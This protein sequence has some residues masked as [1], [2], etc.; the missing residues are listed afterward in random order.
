MAERSTE[1]HLA[2]VLIQ[3]EMK[4]I[5][6]TLIL[7]LFVNL[8][9]AQNQSNN[10][11]F[12][13]N[14]GITF[15]TNPPTTITGGQTTSGEGCTSISDSNGNLLFYSDGVTVWDSTHSV[16]QN[17]TGL[18]GDF[19]STQSGIILPAPGNNMIYYLVTA[20]VSTSNNPLA[21]SIIDMSL[22]SGLGAVTIKNIALLDTSTEK[23]TA[24]YNQNG[25]DIWIIAHGYPNN[26]FYSFL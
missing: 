26:N 7:I 2:E 15:N 12:G 14:L 4:K 23:V 25:G 8:L 19:S 17:G 10:W 1:T 6:T 9:Y 18:F 3:T 22:N 13:I 24:V 21:Y 11:F 5:N 20:P 16:M